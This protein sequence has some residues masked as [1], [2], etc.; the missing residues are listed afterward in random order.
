[1]DQRLFIVAPS[2]SRFEWF[3][4]DEGLDR[5][6]CHYVNDSL[7]LRGQRLRPDQVILL[8][9]WRGLREWQGIEEAL[10]FVIVTPEPL[11]EEQ[12]AEVRTDMIE[13]LRSLRTDH[14]QVVTAV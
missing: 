12:L 11:S 7:R 8:P 4:H 1:M 2:L 10:Q 3:V 6:R 9:G 5:R 14:P 13:L